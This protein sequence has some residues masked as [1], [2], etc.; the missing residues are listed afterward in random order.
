MKREYSNRQPGSQRRQYGFTLTELMFA[1]AFLAF[2]LLFIVNA[3]VQYMATYNKGLTYKA[4]NQ[5]GRIVFEDMTRAVRV[6]E[7]G[8][9]T[10]LLSQGRLCISGQTYVWNFGNDNSNQYAGNNSDSIDG[11]IRVPDT[12]GELCKDVSNRPSESEVTVIAPGRVAVQE[13]IITSADNGGLYHIELVLGTDG[14]DA[15]TRQ[16]GNFSCPGGRAGQFCAFA[17]FESQISARR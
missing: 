5:T 13:F 9:D 14:E 15:P 7:T 6:S 17:E 1:M 4:I 11:I 10:N 16:G 3:M 2:L 12:T 8:P